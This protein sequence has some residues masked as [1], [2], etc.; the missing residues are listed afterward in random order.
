MTATALHPSGS[1]VSL[2][3]RVRQAILGAAG[4]ALLLFAVPLAGAVAVVV[5]SGT[6]TDLQRYA[7]QAAAAVPDDPVQVG[8]PIAVPRV[9][10]TARI[11]IYTRDGAR[12]AGSG[13]QR[14]ALAAHAA[15]TREHEGREAGQFA[16][17]VPVVSDGVVVGTVRAAIP[18]RG[19]VWRVLAWWGALVVLA[20][21]TLLI[22]RVIAA[23]LAT[24]VATPVE[25]LTDA[26]RALGDGAFDLALPRWGMRETD[27]A[28]TALL[29]TA[30]RSGA[31]VRRERAF[32]RDVSHQLRTPLSGLL[33][34]METAVAESD[35]VRR[36][37]ALRNALSRAR[38]LQ[39]TV[40]DLLA[41]RSSDE[42]A[43]CDVAAEVR[44][45]AT[46]MHL[47]PSRH[48]A[49]R[50]DDVP[51]ARCPAAVVRQVLD[52]LLDNAPKHGARGVTVTVEALGD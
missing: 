45:A 22:T 40:D 50:I 26:A 35:P 46:R 36:D 29:D 39:T 20:G 16:A 21:L 18:V 15:D 7:T 5:H 47:L 42:N 25:Q 51:R 44:G 12:A 52:V 43:V 1:T 9:S 31:V 17:V 48:V 3:T 30:R 38:H 10:G 4:I 8:R 32:T 41:V 33:T 49:L 6:I 27:E 14:S 23:R 28:G 19:V 34:G 37:A 11:G 24:R 2:R 13:P